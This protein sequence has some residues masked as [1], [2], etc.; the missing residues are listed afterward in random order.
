MYISYPIPIHLL[1]KR[2]NERL[3]AAIDGGGHGLTSRITGLDPTVKIPRFG[4]GGF[5]ELMDF[6]WIWDDFGWILDGFLMVFDGFWM[7][8]GWILIDSELLFDGFWMAFDGF[9]MESGWILMG[10]DGF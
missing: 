6:G 4:H 9:W 8:F 7:G 5:G 1:Q 2:S 3:I 10:F